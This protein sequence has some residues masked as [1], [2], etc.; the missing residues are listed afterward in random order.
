MTAFEGW[1]KQCSYDWK[2]IGYPFE[3]EIRSQLWPLA[4]SDAHESGF[5]L[6]VEEI[7]GTGPAFH[8]NPAKSIRRVWYH[9]WVAGKTHDCSQFYDTTMVKW[10]GRMKELEFSVCFDPN[11]PDRCCY[12]KQGRDWRMLPPMGKK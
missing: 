4:Y 8:G 5:W 3:G 12:V 6:Q 11:H 2:R 1:K 10:Y 9:S 7:V